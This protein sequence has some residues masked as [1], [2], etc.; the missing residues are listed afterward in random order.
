MN[1][2]CEKLIKESRYHAM[3][4]KFCISFTDKKAFGST[5][6]GGGGGGVVLHGGRFCRGRLKPYHGRSGGG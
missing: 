5:E 4:I 1:M 3:E 2:T 6:A